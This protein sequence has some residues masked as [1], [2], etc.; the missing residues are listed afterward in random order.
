MG[1]QRA[2][3][4]GANASLRGNV[5]GQGHTGTPVQAESTDTTILA[6][7]NTCGAIDCQ[8]TTASAHGESEVSKTKV[9]QESQGQATYTH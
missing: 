1:P 7:Q 4:H 8:P 3:R 6:E 5:L 2:R 9:A